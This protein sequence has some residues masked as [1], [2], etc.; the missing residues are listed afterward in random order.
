METRF[1]KSRRKPMRRLDVLGDPSSE[2]QD[3]RRESF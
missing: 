3:E 1:G 2:A